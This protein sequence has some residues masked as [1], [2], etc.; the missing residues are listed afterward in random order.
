MFC[1]GVCHDKRSE[2][3]VHAA[4][5]SH[6]YG[7]RGPQGALSGPLGGYRTQNKARYFHS[8]GLPFLRFLAEREIYQEKVS[9][10]FLGWN[11][12]YWL[13]HGIRDIGYLLYTGS[14]L[15]VRLKFIRN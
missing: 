13:C 11:C 1:S 7:R 3:E 6:Q 15:A 14:Y 10:I 12:K 4:S 2:A 5:L 9:V 8:Q